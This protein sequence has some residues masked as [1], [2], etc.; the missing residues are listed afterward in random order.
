LALFEKLTFVC[1]PAGYILFG[2]KSW[3]RVLG[4]V[5]PLSMKMLS[6]IICLF[7]LFKRFIEVVSKPHLGPNSCVAP[8]ARD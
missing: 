1:N 3:D 5:L 6:Y 2:N 7:I 4:K 8:L